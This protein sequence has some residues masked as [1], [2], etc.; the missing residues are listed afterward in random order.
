LA[1]DIEV[2]FW[3]GV[4]RVRYQGAHYLL[5]NNMFRVVLRDFFHGNQLL[6]QY[7]E[8]LQRILRDSLKF[9]HSEKDFDLRH[10][11]TFDLQRLSAVESKIHF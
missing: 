6:V 10:R 7:I 2:L 8:R 5:P 1:T 3:S 11:L 9:W 4:E